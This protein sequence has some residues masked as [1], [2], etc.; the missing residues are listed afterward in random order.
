M[1]P[2]QKA[3]VQLT[4]V[5]KTYL[6]RGARATRVLRGI[7]LC[8]FGGC[9]VAIVGPS[10]TGKTT[11][12]R[13]LAGFDLDFDGTRTVNEANGLR[14]AWCPQDGAVADWG[15]VRSN[16]AL[17]VNDT[18]DDLEIETRIS[19]AL[20]AVELSEVADRY[21]KALSTG[22]RQRIGIARNL[23]AMA[24]IY[25]FDEPFAN[26]D[27]GLRVR[28]GNRLRE[29]FKGPSGGPAVV[30]VL[31]DVEDAIRVADSIVLISGAPA[32]VCWRVS[33]E[34]EKGEE[35]TT[36]EESDVARKGDVDAAA[37]LRKLL[38]EAS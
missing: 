17:G 5:S 35:G 20:T 32:E 28:I 25:F 30:Y 4:S 22:M 9:A 29:K 38:M 36:C 3:K 26:L 27:L 33:L 23:A 7:N 8:L 16:V 6:A 34:K 24:D 2:R 13:I 1:S 11:L 10:G 21:P 37:I 12:L 14:I 19:H 15:T 18:L 31:H